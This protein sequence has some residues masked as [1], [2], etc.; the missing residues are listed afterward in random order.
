MADEHLPE[1][2]H[3]TTE[4]VLR[5]FDDFDSAFT[6]FDGD[7]IARRFATPYVACRADGSAETFLDR[8]ATARYFADVL[9]DYRSSGVRS[10]AHEDVEVVDVG[11]RHVLAAVTW[12]LADDSGG[13]VMSWR[14]AYLLVVDEAQLLVRTSIDFP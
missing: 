8:R 12:V 10:C 9:A 2:T 1:P 5:F 4:S 3:E 14:E 13:A 7:V 6:T 11:A